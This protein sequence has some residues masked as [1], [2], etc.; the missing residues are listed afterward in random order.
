MKDACL[1]AAGNAL[2]SFAKISTRWMVL[3]A[4]KPIDPDVGC[5]DDAGDVALA[6]AAETE[7]RHMGEALDSYGYDEA[8]R[9]VYGTSYPEWKERHQR[10]VTED[11]L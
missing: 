5:S 7:R 8:A 9:G 11:Q 2:L 4:R 6:F 3:E 10:K 1:D